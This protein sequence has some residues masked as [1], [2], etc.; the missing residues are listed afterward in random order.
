MNAAEARQATT[1]KNAQLTSVLAKIKRAA[2][3][4]EFFVDT[5]DDLSGRTVQSLRELG[6][7]VKYHDGYWGG[8]HIVYWNEEKKKRFLGFL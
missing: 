1:G 7:R 6:Y 8:A 5:L 4:G 2:E 3:E